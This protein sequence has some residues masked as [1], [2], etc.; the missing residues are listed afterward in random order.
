MKALDN[1]VKNVETILARDILHYSLPIFR[2]TPNAKKGFNRMIMMFQRTFWWGA[3]Y[4]LVFSSCIDEQIL[5]FS[6]RLLSAT[7][8]C[9]Q[10]DLKI[11]FPDIQ[12][13]K[14]LMTLNWLKCHCTEHV[15]AG[16]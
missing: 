7:V 4:R 15:F 11:E 5:V 6:L 1:A 3:Q 16:P 14:A 10:Y 9:L 13:N 8:A 2:F 12:V